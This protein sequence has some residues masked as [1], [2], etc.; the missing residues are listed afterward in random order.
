MTVTAVRAGIETHEAWDL[1]GGELLAHALPELPDGSHAPVCLDQLFT[2]E[3]HIAATSKQTME[4]YSP[5]KRGA[6]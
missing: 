2:R 6:Y 5:P 3:L 4:Q 1:P